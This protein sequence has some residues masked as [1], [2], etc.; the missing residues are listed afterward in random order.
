MISILRQLKSSVVQNFLLVSFSFP[1]LSLSWTKMA[2]INSL[3]IT[4]SSSYVFYY[5]IWIGYMFSKWYK[6]YI[7]S[8]DV[9]ISLNKKETDVV[10]LY[11]HMLSFLF[12]FLLEIIFISKLRENNE[13]KRMFN[14]SVT[15]LFC[16]ANDTSNIYFHTTFNSFHMI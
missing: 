8:Q 4:W 9:I 2:W 7:N 14:L 3:K 5:F 11:M 10:N 1:R 13:R 15:Y 6:R 16:T 12:S